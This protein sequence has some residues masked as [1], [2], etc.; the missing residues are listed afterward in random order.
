M[1]VLIQPDVRVR[2]S[3]VEALREFRNE[4]RGAADDMSVIGRYIRER[5]H[6]VADADAFAAF[7]AE[8]RADRLED[9]PRPAGF[10]PS[11]ELWWVDGDEFLGRI[12][13]RH[14]LTPFLL[15]VGGHIGYDVRPG[16]RRRGHAT[17]MLRAALSEARELGIDRAL[18]TCDVD[19]VGSRTVIERNGGVLEDQ[20]GEKL[21]YW[22]PT[23]SERQE[24]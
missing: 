8:V 17:A 24:S 9:S 14:R 22:V 3:F 21:R 19:N 11:T 13:I 18:V 15:D 16:A 1:P 7:V 10:V 5:R 6:A 12:G 20:R 23:F 4:G 2:E